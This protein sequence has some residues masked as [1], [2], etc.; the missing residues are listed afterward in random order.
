MNMSE[1]EA[2]K[3]IEILYKPPSLKAKDIQ[4]AALS[5]ILSRDT[6]EA[7]RRI[8]GEPVDQ[9]DVNEG[10][11]LD[12]IKDEVELIKHEI[13]AE[14]IELR[15]KMGECMT[16]AEAN[17]GEFPEASYQSA[18]NHQTRIEVLILRLAYLENLIR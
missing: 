4:L 14:D 2:E 13:E 5:P 16:Y 9:Y 11:R 12:K 15:I 3:T 18:C 1:K 17:N 6:A 8:M 10:D 7:L